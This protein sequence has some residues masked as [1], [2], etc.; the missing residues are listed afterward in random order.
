MKG[1]DPFANMPRCEAKTRAA[2]PV[3]E[4]ATPGITDVFFMAVAPA[5]QQARKTGDGDTATRP[6]QRKQNVE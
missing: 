6:G 5:R 3:A 4:S 1:V 2:P